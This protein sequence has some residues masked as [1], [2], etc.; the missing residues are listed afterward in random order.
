VL[1]T[2]FGTAAVDAVHDGAWQQM[3]AAHGPYIERVPIAD[4]V[5]KLKTLDPEL[6]RSVAEVFFG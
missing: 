4:A 6:F 2:R 5:A 3:V 1:A